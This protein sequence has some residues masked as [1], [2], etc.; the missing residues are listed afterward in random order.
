MVLWKVKGAAGCFCR[1]LAGFSGSS[2]KLMGGGTS[3]TVDARESV[4]L[5][6]FLQIHNFFT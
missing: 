4:I 5:K 3:M 2:K 1:W 6:K